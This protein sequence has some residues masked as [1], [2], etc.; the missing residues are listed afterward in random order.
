MMVVDEKALNPNINN[1]P[2]GDDK[3]VR[4][5]QVSKRFGDF[6]AVD[7]V[8]INIRQGEIFALLGSSGCGKSTLLR[9]L[10]GFETPTEGRILVDGVDLGKI[11]PYKRP[12]NMMFQSYAL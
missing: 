1:K 3:Y 7:S 9:M 12:I 11:P 6:T 4:V 5:E 10:A 8:S 2:K